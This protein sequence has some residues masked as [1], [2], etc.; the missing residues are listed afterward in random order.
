VQKERAEM[1]LKISLVVL[2]TLLGG[3]LVA[4]PAKNPLFQ[5]TKTF[6]ES[7]TRA[8]ISLF[9]EPLTEKT[10]QFIATLTKE[11]PLSSGPQVIDLPAKQLLEAIT[12]CLKELEGDSKTASETALQ[13][14][15][16]SKTGAVV[17]HLVFSKQTPVNEDHNITL[18]IT[19]YGSTPEIPPHVL[20]LLKETIQGESLFKRHKM[21]IVGIPCAAVLAG[22]ILGRRNTLPSQPGAGNSAG[23]TPGLPGV[24]QLD[25]TAQEA[26]PTA[27]R[28]APTPPAVRRVD[29]VA[30]EPSSVPTAPPAGLEAPQMATHDAPELERNALAQ[31]LLD[32]LGHE[33]STFTDR[34]P[35]TH[36]NPKEENRDLFNTL[37]FTRNNLMPN[38]FQSLN[39]QQSS[40]SILKTFA[41]LAQHTSIS[42]A[43]LGT[44]GNQVQQLS[45]YGGLNTYV[46]IYKD[47][48]G[49]W[50]LFYYEKD[51]EGAL[52]LQ[53][54]GYPSFEGTLQQLGY[55]IGQF[56]AA[57]RSTK[58]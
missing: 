55:L 7:K 20:A 49:Q 31:A 23:T 27:S 56:N 48:G 24:K 28:R 8:K 50:C 30:P 13:L 36:L 44:L 53:H 14:E 42:R 54:I 3:S 4:N 32:R 9:Y 34:A 38:D 10:P 17:A 46:L 47:L 6:A 35:E 33:Y 39:R 12:K 21:K 18:T 26:P 16:T 57:I 58:K 43:Q 51:S 5:T 22:I 11:Q 37:V 45:A 15:Q 25:L 41:I 19:V 29:R 40:G 2:V 52:T 1:N